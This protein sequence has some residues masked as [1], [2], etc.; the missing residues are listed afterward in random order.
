MKRKAN[1]GDSTNFN[2]DGVQMT[3]IVGITPNMIPPFNQW[4]GNKQKVIASMPTH[5]GSN[6]DRTTVIQNQNMM[7][8]F[9]MPND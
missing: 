9:S 5:G 8:L 6:L 7:A 3:D 1:F 2:N 4:L